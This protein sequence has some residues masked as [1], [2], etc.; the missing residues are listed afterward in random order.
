MCASSSMMTGRVIVWSSSTESYDSGSVPK[1]SSEPGGGVVLGARRPEGLGC[2]RVGETL[3]LEEVEGVRRFSGEP[4]WGLSRACCEPERRRSFTG[5]VP[6]WCRR[7]CSSVETGMREV[8]AR[9]KGQRAAATAASGCSCHGDGRS[10]LRSE[11]APRLQHA[12]R[13]C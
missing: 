12:F 9:A 7:M 13:D 8:R 4:R 10:E 11:L 3:A 5:L 1:S 2:A 6:R